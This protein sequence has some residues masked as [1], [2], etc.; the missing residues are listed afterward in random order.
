MVVASDYG[1]HFMFFSEVWKGDDADKTKYDTLGKYLDSLGIDKGTDT[2]ADYFDKQKADWDK[3]E[4]D[5]SFLYILANELISNKLSDVSSQSSAAIK[6]KY[7]YGD[8]KD[9][10]KIYED[11]IADLIG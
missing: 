4:E 1:Y 7:R 11:A 10:T 8:M 9:C 3:F 2:W 6:A 5:N